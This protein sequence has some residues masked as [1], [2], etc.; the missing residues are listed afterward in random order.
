M[1]HILYLASGSGHRFG[2]NKL[3]Y[4]YRGKPLFQWGLETLCTLAKPRGDCAITV[5]SRYP[6]IRAWAL[7]EG[8]SA[9][10][11]PESEKGISYTIRAGLA[12]L[13]DVRLKDYLLFAAADQPHISVCSAEKLLE[14]ACGDTECA[15]L[16]W[17][18][19]PGN[20]TLFSASLIPELLALEG[21]RGGRAVL[22]QHR[23]TF[24]SVLDPQE[25]ADID[26]KLSL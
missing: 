3:L 8:C 20:P 19:T 10:D 24:V 2:S 13:G 6:E 17:E 11:S 12:A 14:L 18:N 25:L 21:D 15:S 23:C 4:P 9:V 1:I 26:T 7:R 16:C 5:V 22:K